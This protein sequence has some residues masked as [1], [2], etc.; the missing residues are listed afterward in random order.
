MY[1]GDRVHSHLLLQL[2]RLGQEKRERGIPPL[3]RQELLG[4]H[5][6]G[7]GNGLAVLR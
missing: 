1:S 4:Q 3:R 7:G 6:H 2:L 5:H